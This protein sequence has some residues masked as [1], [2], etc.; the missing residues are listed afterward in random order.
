MSEH[1]G[2]DRTLRLTTTQLNAHLARSGSLTDR[3]DNPLLLARSGVLMFDV[4]GHRPAGDDWDVRDAPYSLEQEEGY[5]RDYE[6]TSDFADLFAVGEHL[7]L[8]PED[9]VY[10]DAVFTTALEPAMCSTPTIGS[11][12]ALAR[13]VLSYTPALEN[14]S[15]TGFLERAI[16]GKRPPPGLKALRAVSLGPPPPHWFI[17]LHLTHPALD[18]IEKLRICGS[19]LLNLEEYSI[20]GEDGWLS[21]LKEFQYSTA[22]KEG[23]GR[24]AR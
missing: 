8:D 4:H 15:L 6:G 9:D 13:S 18:R 10:P 22:T 3:L 16:C 5:M 20:C 11:L 1:D 12:L 7:E 17:F 21:G 14:V 24:R 19:V 23:Y 2:K